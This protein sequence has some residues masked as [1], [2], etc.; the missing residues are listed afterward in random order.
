MQILQIV[1]SKHLFFNQSSIRGSYV[2]EKCPLNDSLN[3][4]IMSHCF[5]FLMSKN[6]KSL[7]EVRLYSQDTNCFPSLKKCNAL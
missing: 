4:Y 1:V 3:F 2:K 6:K 7:C 5:S